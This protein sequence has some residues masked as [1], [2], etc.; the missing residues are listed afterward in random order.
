VGP[1]GSGKDAAVKYLCEE[2]RY[3]RIT[4]YTTRERRDIDDKHIFIDK[5]I[6]D[7]LANKVACN[8]YCGNWY[9]TTKNDVDNNDL[10]IIEPNGV[11]DFKNTYKGNKGV[12]VIGLKVPPSIAAKRMKQRGDSEQAIQIRIKEDAVL[13]A[14]MDTYC[15]V[16]V[17]T[18]GPVNSVGRFI[19]AYIK[20][21]EK[22]PENELK[23]TDRI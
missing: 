7:T 17:N 10:Y 8:E 21:E 12:K 23:E 1:S 5:F 13:F 16:I 15:D 9:T 4:S 14:D 11:K 3:T 20:Y 18:Y 22:G 2:Y 6:F 19:N